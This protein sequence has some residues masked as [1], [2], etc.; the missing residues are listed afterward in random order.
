MVNLVATPIFFSYLGAVGYGYWALALAFSSTA[1]GLDMGMSVGLIRAIPELKNKKDYESL[2]TLATAVLF[3]YLLFSII[4]VVAALLFA[5]LLAALFNTG[6]AGPEELKKVFVLAALLLSASSFA[7]IT[8]ATIQGLSR[9]DINSYI[10]T[11]TYLVFA[12]LGVLF[13]A[14]GFGLTGLILAF[15]I[16]FVLQIIFGVAIIARLCPQMRPSLRLCFSKK[17]WSYLINFGSRLQVSSLSDIFK[18]QAPKLL[19]GVFFGPA[20]AGVY[21]L[22]NRLANAGWVLPVAFLPVIIPTASEA[23]SRG[24]IARLQNLYI[25]GSKWLLAIALP[26]AACLTLFSKDFLKIWLGGGHEE[27]AFVLICLALAN[28]LHLLTGVGT[29]IGR[30]IAKPNAEM[31]Y[32]LLTLF[33]YVAFVYILIKIFGFDGIPLG[34]AIAC[35]MG[36]VY[37]LYIFS[38]VIKVTLRLFIKRA[39][40]PPLGFL[41]PA[42]LLVIPSKLMLQSY[43]APLL[44]IIMM[45]GLLIAIYMITIGLWSH[46]AG[47]GGP[48][49]LLSD[50]RAAVLAGKPDNA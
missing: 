28:I 16:M 12:V 5:P 45:G 21:D 3:F 27:I 18:T 38:H 23:N 1:G 30:G 19:A 39:I 35:A 13:L 9:F 10:F 11:S 36:S 43:L 41:I 29:F 33:M 48:A 2:A 49:R 6:S 7:G 40:I 26:L 42:L 14:A 4:A 46:H 50:V 34:I 15:C 25:Q 24:E 32:Q 8:S 47:K 37:F 22:G 31:K 44:S 17:A 20:A